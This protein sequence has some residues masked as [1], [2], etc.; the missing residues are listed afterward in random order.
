M[1][2]VVVWHRQ[3]IFLGVKVEEPLGRIVL[4]VRQEETQ[5]EEEV[6]N[7]VGSILHFLKVI[8]QFLL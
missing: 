6:V 1:W 5:S 3:N 7:F 8:Q 2:M 4:L